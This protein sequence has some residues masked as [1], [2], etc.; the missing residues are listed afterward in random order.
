MG[1]EFFCCLCVYCMLEWSGNENIRCR[2]WVF[3]CSDLV[4]ETVVNNADIRK[5]KQIMQAVEISGSHGSSQ[6][7]VIQKKPC[8]V[9]RMHQVPGHGKDIEKSWSRIGWPKEMVRDQQ[10]DL[11]NLSTSRG[12]KWYNSCSAGSWAG[13]LDSFVDASKCAT[14]WWCL[15]RHQKQCSIDVFWCCMILYTSKVN[16]YQQC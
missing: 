10:F 14:R 1:H 8:I 13:C 11:V 3:S 2:T 16:L 15:N 7:S 6:P 12:V 5:E 4:R 9:L